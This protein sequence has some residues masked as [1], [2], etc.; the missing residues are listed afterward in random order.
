MEKPGC[1][2][3]CMLL[4]QG[5]NVESVA[6]SCIYCVTFPRGGLAMDSTSSSVFLSV[7]LSCVCPWKE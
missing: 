5:V 3:C 2:A 6:E 7:C 1:A 4:V